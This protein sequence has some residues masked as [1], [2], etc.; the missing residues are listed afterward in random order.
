MKG[1][2]FRI[3]SIMRWILSATCSRSPPKGNSANTGDRDMCETRILLRWQLLHVSGNR[4]CCFIYWLRMSAQNPEPKSPTE[5]SSMEKFPS[6]ANTPKTIS[7]V[8]MLRTIENPDVKKKALLFCKQTSSQNV[9]TLSCCFC[10]R[11]LMA[12][13]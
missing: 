5:K 9:R 10:C 3:S 8:W 2:H 6:Q 7:N 11:Q 13:N 4:K 1:I 12:A